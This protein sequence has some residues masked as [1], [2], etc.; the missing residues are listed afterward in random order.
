MAP[1]TDDRTWGHTVAPT[2]TVTV[3]AERKDGGRQDIVEFPADGKPCSYTYSYDTPP[4]GRGHYYGS[5]TFV[6]DYNDWT[7]V[8]AVADAAN[9]LA[10]V[11]VRLPDPDWLRHEFRDPRLP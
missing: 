2:G 9:Y 3:Y 10:K 5:R 8:E 6:G 1:A 4:E 7:V 11:G